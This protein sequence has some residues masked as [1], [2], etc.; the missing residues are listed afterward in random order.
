LDVARSRLYGGR[1]KNCFRHLRLVWLAP[2]VAILPRVYAASPADSAFE[3]LAHECIEALLVAGPEDATKLGDHRYDDRLTDYSSA[4]V[5]AR[6]AELR[7]EL[8][9]LEKIDV[10]S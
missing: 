2:L 8:A 9:A 3:K 10:G 6:I 1:M 7:A 4:A 5:A